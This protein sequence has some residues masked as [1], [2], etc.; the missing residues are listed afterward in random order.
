MFRHFVALFFLVFGLNSLCETTYVGTEDKLLFEA[1][2]RGGD[3][4]QRVKDIRLFIKGIMYQEGRVVQEDL[5]KAREI[6][7]RLSNQPYPLP[8]AQTN[9]AWMLYNGVGGEKD[10]QGGLQMYY[11]AS[12]A[13]VEAAIMSLASIY[14]EQNNTDL[15][16]SMYMN[17]YNFHRNAKA[18]YEL[19]I[20][21]YTGKS[22]LKKNIR[23]AET[24]FETAINDKNNADAYYK[25]GEIKRRNKDYQKAFEVYQYAVLNHDHVESLYE[26]TILLEEEKAVAQLDD[27]VLNVALNNYG[28][29]YNEKGHTKSAYRVARIFEK[30]GMN[31]HAVKWYKKAAEKST[32]TRHFDWV[33][34]TTGE[35]L[36]RL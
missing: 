22:G 17:A 27:T 34:Y 26:S 24:Y 14:L 7:N 30:V 23:Y 5:I 10:T 25:L 20:A 8:E 2:G 15:A 1:M 35:S 11:Q 12:I 6:Y 13:N 9:Y 32:Q 3:D 28:Y 29:L 19:G 4:T 36:V 18:A 21:Y 33:K 31:S 16:Y